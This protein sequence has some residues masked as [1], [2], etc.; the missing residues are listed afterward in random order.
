MD[1]SAGLG[2]TFALQC[3]T[4]LVLGLTVVLVVLCLGCGSVVSLCNATLLC[5]QSG[6]D[7][8]IQSHQCFSKKYQHQ[9]FTQV[10]SVSEVLIFFIPIQNISL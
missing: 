6:C 10:F 8:E 4:V 5:E 2:S 7:F 9:A 1:G 3:V